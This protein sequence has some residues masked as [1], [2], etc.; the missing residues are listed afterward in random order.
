MVLRVLGIRVLGL[1]EGGSW[2][3]ECVVARGLGVF[4]GFRSFQV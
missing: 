3:V 1:G 2:G 4:R